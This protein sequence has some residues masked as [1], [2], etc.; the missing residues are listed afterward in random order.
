MTE[1]KNRSTVILGGLLVAT[2]LTAAA[3][4]G[5]APDTFSGG[6][7][8]CV[9]PEEFVLAGAVPTGVNFDF[10]GNP[11]VPVVNGGTAPLYDPATNE[12]VGFITTTAVDNGDGTWTVSTEAQT[13]DGQAFVQPDDNVLVPTASGLQ[14]ATDLVLDLGNGYETPGFPVDGVMF[15][16][17]APGDVFVSV[18][19]WY[20]RVDGS[21]NVES[22][23]LTGPFMKE[24]GFTFAW[25]YSL[26]E[27]RTFKRFGYACTFEASMD[28]C[29][30]CPTDL[31]GD[32]EVGGGDLGLLLAGWGS[33]GKAGPGCFGDLNGDG[34]VNGG[35][36][37]LL[38]ASWGDCP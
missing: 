2:T 38:L 1:E 13:A 28:A 12:V 21:M 15:S 9:L 25:G 11:A 35:D 30:G 3:T 18:E 7:A 17:P 32:C 19:Y 34:A 26:P 4:A 23:T 37:G 10:P 33:C 24:N 22:T 29:P 16:A 5:D 14:E 27:A 20:E 6:T 8:L 31:D 36:L